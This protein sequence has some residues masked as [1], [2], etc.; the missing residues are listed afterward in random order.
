MMAG[1]AFR[2]RLVDAAAERYWPAG[3]FAYHFAR[4]KLAGDPVFCELLARGLVPDAAHVLDL[5]CG[6]GLLASWLMAAE[7]CHRAGEWYEGWPP[8][9]T[10]WSFRGVELMSRDVARAR[11]AL[12]EMGSVE[13]GDIRTVDFGMADAVVI[14]DV[15]HYMGTAS[16]EAVL[17]R[18]RTALSP[19]GVLLL[20]IG[21][22]GGGLPFRISNW[23][24][25]AVSFVRGHGLLRL[26]CRS[27]R[28][29]I[30]LLERLGFRT[31]AIPTSAN[32]PFANVLLV[33][34]PR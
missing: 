10:A 2:R 14:L 32:T 7:E 30:A 9:P 15:L 22:A 24:D 18:V 6:Q 29:W 13:V 27:L 25:Q 33:A 1:R 26:H 3:R 12:A 8:P 20:R 19:S 34:R 11:E 21:D 28:D 17:G 16:Q 5:G 4:G 23:V 31:D